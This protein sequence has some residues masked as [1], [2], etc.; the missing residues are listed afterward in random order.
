[1]IY[2]LSRV[3]LSWTLSKRR[4]L[5]PTLTGHHRGDKAKPATSISC[6]NRYP[7][8]NSNAAAW[9]S[10]H[11]AACSPIEARADLP[12][13]RADSSGVRASQAGAMDRPSI[14]WLPPRSMH[15]DVLEVAW[16]VCIRRV[17]DDEAL[18]A[19]CRVAFLDMTGLGPDRG[20]AIELQDRWLCNSRRIC[21]GLGTRLGEGNARG[22]GT[23][24]RK[25]STRSWP[26]CPPV[27]VE[28]CQW[29]RC[30]CN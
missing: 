7:S 4:P 25:G 17:L 2:Q 27:K 9:S 5:P 14:S 28:I 23:W 15:M 20:R 29:C 10:W 24:R 18:L 13:C 30:R 12:A 26:R 6:L 22:P 1:M 11:P 3:T 16:K 21:Q 8:G 19:C